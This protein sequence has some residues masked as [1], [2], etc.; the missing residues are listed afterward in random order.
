MY[1]NDNEDRLAGNYGGSA[2]VSNPANADKTWA[3]G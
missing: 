3:L 2:F 1:A